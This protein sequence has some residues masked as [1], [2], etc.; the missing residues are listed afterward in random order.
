[1]SLDEIYSQV[2]IESGQFLF[3]GDL[4]I[5]LNRFRKLVQPALDIYS[6]YR[7]VDRKFN[8]VVTGMSYDF[9]GHDYGV[10]DWIS[11]VML[12]SIPYN[13][14]YQDIL[15]E[16]NNGVDVP[17][18][19]PFEY[20]PPILYVTADGEYDVTAVYKHRLEYDGQVYYVDTIDTSDELF[21]KLLA[22]KFLQALG[23]A[24]KAFVLEGF[25]IAVDGVDLVSE[26][27]G[28]E[29][30]ALEQLGELSKWYLAWG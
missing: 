1:M 27:K 6:K 19:A 10:P 26:G 17:R 29:Q 13:A 22:G 14:I 28:L 5:D 16:Y 4:E 20:R 8:I 30:E 18:K 21:F 25:P 2:L 12:V 9:T 11:K 23:R 24:R 7:P 15:Q 3:E